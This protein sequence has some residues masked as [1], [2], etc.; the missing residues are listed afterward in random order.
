[1]GFIFNMKKN[2]HKLKKELEKDP[3]SNYEIKLDILKEK[4]DERDKLN[5]EIKELKKELKLK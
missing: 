4:I 1:M 3:Y 5:R 2:K